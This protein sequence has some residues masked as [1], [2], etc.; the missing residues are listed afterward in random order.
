MRKQA[1][2]SQIVEYAGRV[3]QKV[4]AEAVNN[5]MDE[6]KKKWRQYGLDAQYYGKGQ[7]ASGRDGIVQGKRLGI[8]RRKIL[9]KASFTV[10][11]KRA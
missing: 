5:S 7:Q 9:Q 11:K 6:K 2:H 3:S 10:G 4:Q 1:L 8:L